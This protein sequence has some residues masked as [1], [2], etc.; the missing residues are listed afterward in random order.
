M[1]EQE[2][3]KRMLQKAIE[4]TEKANIQSSQ[5]MIQTLIKELRNTHVNLD[6]ISK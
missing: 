6:T 3:Y 4:E 5:E 1:G 2:K